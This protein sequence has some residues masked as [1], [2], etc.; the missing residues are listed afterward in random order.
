MKILIIGYSNI[1]RKRIFKLFLKKNIKLFIASKSFRGD[2][3]GIEKQYKSYNYA[4]KNSKPDL[5]YISLPNSKHFYWAKK[6]LNNNCHTIVDKPI[7]SNLNELKLLIQIAK[8]KKK[9]L[10][11]STFFN[12]HSQVQKLIKIYKKN[13]FNNIFAKFTIP[14][15]EKKSI[16]L[17]RNLGGG[18]LMDMG[19]YIS[20][21]P[22]IFNLKKIIT[23][24][25]VIKKNNK[26]IITFI[27]LKIKFKDCTYNGIFKFGGKYKNQ[28][29]INKDY[30]TARIQRVF[31]P[32][33]NE[34]LL[35]KTK[36]KNKTKILKFKKEDCFKNY[37]EEIQKNLK[38]KKFDFYC[39]R[40]I[41]DCEFRSN[42]TL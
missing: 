32:P 5:I 10:S 11:E 7:T 24:N 9:L 6:S 19:P 42:L 2:I 39:K 27:K 3:I 15:P 4:I 23:K 16:L 40:M 33:D 31:S 1:V 34:I 41:A 14:M 29:E 28:I 8:K 22:R 35:L 12:Y 30:E 25:I 20:A 18:V 21:I 26:K 17:S 37:F 38:N 13:K 36:N